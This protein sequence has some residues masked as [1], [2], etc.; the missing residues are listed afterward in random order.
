MKVLAFIGL[1][2]AVAAVSGEGTT[3]HGTTAEIHLQ[4]VPAVTG[5]GPR[6]KRDFLSAPGHSILQDVK[7]S[8]AANAELSNAVVGT[9][10]ETGKI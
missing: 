3:T 1:T 10:N 9:T 6:H 2:L 7:N 4:T 8:P 5:N